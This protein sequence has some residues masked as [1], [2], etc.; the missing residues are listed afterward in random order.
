MVPV[1]ADCSFEAH[2]PS[3]P[4][5]APAGNLAEGNWRVDVTAGGQTVTKF[6]GV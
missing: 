2:F 3:A 6:H 4:G 5:Q 1:G